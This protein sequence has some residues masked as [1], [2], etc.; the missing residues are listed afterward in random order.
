MR[1][2]IRNAT[3]CFAVLLCIGLAASFGLA[4][5][6][7]TGGAIIGEVKD[8]SGAVLAGAKVTAKSTQT[9]LVREVSTNEDGSYR[10]PAL[11]VGTYDVTVAVDGFAPQ[12]LRTELLVGQTANLVFS[13]TVG[14]AS[15]E[16]VQVTT[17]SAPIVETART[18]QAS[19]IS[20]R[21]I[22]ELPVNGRNFLEF[23][24]LTPGVNTDPRTGD[25]SFGGLRGTLNSLLIDGS[26]N[27]NTFFGQSIGRTGS[28]RAPYQFSQSSVREFQVNTNGYAAEFG[29]AGGAVINVVTKSG[30]NDFHGD[31]FL[32][33]RDRSLNA[34]DAFVRAARRPNPKFRVYQFGAT[35]GGPIVKDK[36]F[37]FFNYD[38]QRR[39]D[40][41]VVIFGAAVPGDAAS[42][43]VARQLAPFLA[44][45]DTKF[46]QDVYIGKVDWQ[47]NPSHR[48]SVRY[49]R[50]NFT[51]TNLENA[52]AT[53]AAEHSGNSLV[54]TDTVTNSLT[55]L[56]RPNLINEFRYLFS[57]DKEPG[58][59]N[60]T[61]P[62]A[63]ILQ[64][65]LTIITIGRNNF[66][67]RETTEKRNQ[68]I[69]TLTY[70]RGNH[71]YKF[72]IDVNINRIFNFF[73]GLFTG[74]YTFTSLADFADGKP[75]GGYRQ[76]FAGSG[77]NGPVSRPNSTEIAW[78][79][80]DDWSVRQNLKLYLGVRYDVQL[81]EEPPVF[82]P[83]S[84]L[85]ALGVV[86]DR[87][88]QDK[89]NFAPRLGFAWQP[90][91]NSKTVVRGGYGIFYGRTPSI[92]TGTAHTQN[93]LSVRQL[94]FTGAN[95]PTYPQNFV[96]PPTT[97]VP[98][99]PALYYF[100]KDF[101]QPVIHQASFGV[102]RELAKD[103]SLNVSYLMVRGLRQTQSRDINFSQVVPTRVDVRSSTAV[104][105]S[106]NPLG[107]LTGTLLL[108]RFG[109]RPAT[110][111]DRLTG[112]FSTGDSIYHGLTVQLNKR[113]S[114]NFQGL[115]S[116]T[117][118]HVIDNK[119]DATSVVVG[120]GDDAKVV[121][122][123]LDPGTDRGDGETD[124]RHRFVANYVWDLNYA[125]NIQNKVVKFLLE[126]YS[127]SGILTA[128]SG[129]PYSAQVGGDLNGDRNSRTDRSPFIGRNTFRTDKFVQYDMRLSRTITFNE[130][131]RLQL[132]AEGFNMFN[133]FNVA[134]INSNQ[135]LFSTI[136]GV[137]TIAPNPAF[138]AAVSGVG[139]NIPRQ[140]QLAAKF[141]F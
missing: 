94:A 19:N 45:Y 43:A 78:F 34:K 132:F 69:D 51:G 54:T 125:K 119:P 40:P 3:Y 109:A 27:N 5:S 140:F 76:A 95:V 93:G 8:P 112:F 48:Y 37:F 100:D 74:T 84:Q 70:L 98:A 55:S 85:A 124:V 83:D 53:S 90:F 10:I 106:G 33:F 131:Y 120:G 15:G 39:T 30:T 129:R 79:V 6:R 133:R 96:T 62:E 73:P 103:L 104:D 60:S 24:R 116:Y 82:N 114:H 72:G 1:N 118:S 87:L 86:T 61:N 67:P 71:S 31:A 138:G 91:S 113:F 42:Q 111:F 137:P 68:F 110:R 7:S 136:K 9:G 105:A 26:D 4:Q 80:Q 11:D 130:R 77:T 101:V 128:T 14:G 58:S 126:G 135:F 52:G 29:R 81:I 139:N 141:I 21:Q 36:A 38:G 107:T 115:I 89:N 99:T 12:T 13:L 50:Q 102:E 123:T 121:Q 127:I 17:D 20:D 47:I 44:P 25:I 108:P 41:N 117:W 46:N 28:G 35:I 22:R 65:G 57:R 18:H 97:G 88:K 64:G 122:N 2:W 75:S 63:Q 49:N 92:V 134:G 23:V 66:S 16:I 59:A 56:I 32:Y